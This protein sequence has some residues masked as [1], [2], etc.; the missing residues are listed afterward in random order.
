MIWTDIQNDSSSG[1]DRIPPDTRQATWAMNRTTTVFTIPVSNSM[2]AFDGLDIARKKIGKT[3]KS[4]E[5]LKSCSETKLGL[6]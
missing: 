3:P 1:R 2:A 4:I 5:N 6:L